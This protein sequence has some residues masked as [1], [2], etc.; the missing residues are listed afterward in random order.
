MLR[1]FPGFPAS[2]LSL[3]SMTGWP[4]NLSSSAV[5]LW[6]WPHARSVGK[7]IHTSSALTTIQWD[8]L[9][10]NVPITSASSKAHFQPKEKWEK[11][12]FIKDVGEQATKANQK[13]AEKFLWTRKQTRKGWQRTRA[14]TLQ[15]SVGGWA[16]GN[17]S[18]LPF[19]KGRRSGWHSARSFGTISVSRLPWTSQSYRVGPQKGNSTRGWKMLN[20]STWGSTG[21][22][23]PPA[24]CTHALNRKRLVSKCSLCPHSEGR[25]SWS[26]MGQE[27][28]KPGRPL[29]PSPSASFPNVSSHPGSPCPF[30][31]KCEEITKEHQKFEK[32]K[33][34]RNL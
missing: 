6:G 22:R 29:I 17:S 14:D 7:W 23:S 15:A 3:H 27:R 1:T 26:H 25:M 30:F 32:K 12:M 24:T 2:Q 10:Q 11:R 8:F 16:Q 19:P 18:E 21:R 5:C 33:K 4:G 34:K 13:K 20:L 31:Q 9:A 28:G